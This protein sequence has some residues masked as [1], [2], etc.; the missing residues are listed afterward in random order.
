MDEDKILNE[1]ASDDPDTAKIRREITRLQNNLFNDTARF[2]DIYLDTVYR[3]YFYPWTYYQS[4]TGISARQ[5]KELFSSFSDNG[6]DVVDSLNSMQDRLAPGD[7]HLCTSNVLT[8]RDI[9][10]RKGKCA[11]GIVSF[12]KVFLT[13]TKTKGLL[14]FNFYCGGLCGFGHLLLIEKVNNK[15]RIIQTRATWIS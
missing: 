2:C 6:Q 4:D 9:K 11:I 3:P 1:Y 15:W 5:T 13:K 12:S 10:N 7:F 8:I 14:Y